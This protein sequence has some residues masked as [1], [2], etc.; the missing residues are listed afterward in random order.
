M[1]TLNLLPDTLAICRLSP[2][3]EVPD[4][5]LAADFYSITRTA[6]ELSIVCH[7]RNVPND[8]QHEGDW[9]CLKVQGPLPFSMIGVMASLAV[10]LADAGISLFVIS[11]FDTD[12]LLVKQDTLQAASAALRRAGHSITGY[13]DDGTTISVQ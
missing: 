6:D 13:R 3:A 4:W 10:P 9:R 12:Y 1:L 2:D 11:T 5:A 8:V 7:Q